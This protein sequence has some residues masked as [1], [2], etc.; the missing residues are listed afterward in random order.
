MIGLI[1]GVVLMFGLGAWLGAPFLPIRRVDTE[2]ILDLAGLKSGESL[3]DLGSGTGSLLRAG[4][5]RGARCYGYEIN[6]LLYLYSLVAC[7]PYRREVRITFGNYWQTAWPETDVIYTFLIMRYMPKLSKRLD[8]IQRPTRF[9][10]YV[11]PLPD[12]TP[13][14]H[15]QNSYLYNYPNSAK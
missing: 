4:A 9:V 14:H 1:V 13:V 15:N 5:K 6:P 2:S 7:Y 8:Q 11:F 10:S 3:L 12:R